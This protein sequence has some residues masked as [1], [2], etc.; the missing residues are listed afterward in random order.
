MFIEQEA[1]MIY[2][3]SA[4]IIL[5]MF[6]GFYFAKILIQKRQFIKTNQM[7][8]GNKSKKVLLIERIMSCATILACIVGVCSIFLVKQLPMTGVRIAGIVIGILGVIFF[9]TA[10]ISM[11]T[12]WRVGIPEEKTVLVT[13]GIY[14][15]SRNPA[16]VGFDL[17]Y[18]SICLMFPNVVLVVVSVWAGVMLHM[19]ILQ[20]EEHMHQMFGEE[21][22][23]YKNITLRYWGRR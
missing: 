2:Q 20:E 18:L 22:E 17:M 10:T 23:V 12:S 8:V 19:Q 9:A 21:Y 13:Q 14:R 6:Y 11:K 16:F 1:G 4:I 7:G 5:I 15:W 3:I